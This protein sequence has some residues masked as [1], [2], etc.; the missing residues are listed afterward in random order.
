LKLE[1]EQRKNQ[2][3]IDDARARYEAWKKIAATESVEDATKM[4]KYMVNCSYGLHDFEHPRTKEVKSLYW[5]LENPDDPI[6]GHEAATLYLE[7]FSEPCVPGSRWADHYQNR[8]DYER[9]MLEADGGTAT[10]IEMVAGGWIGETQICKVNKSPAT[11]AVVSIGVWGKHPWRTNPDG[12][13]EMGI[14]TVNI[15]RIGRECGYRAPTAEELA[16][17]QEIMKER[18][19][20]AN[21]KKPKAPPMINP[22]P[23]AAKT[24]Q[25]AINKN[26]RKEDGAEPMEMTQKEYSARSKSSFRSCETFYIRIDEAGRPVLDAAN[27]D[28]YCQ[29][30]DKMPILCRVRAGYISGDGGGYRVIVL[31]DKPQKAFPAM[32]KPAKEMAIA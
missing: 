5:L 28:M 7:R 25:D 8:L 29:R 21:A 30:R 23:E 27:R 16:E 4:A 31:T 17:F 13:P 12:T 14:Q 2:A 20:K 11:G 24:M 19:G 3:S 1:A 32:P 15:Q 6:N 26:R 18:R 22:T 10:E 9:A